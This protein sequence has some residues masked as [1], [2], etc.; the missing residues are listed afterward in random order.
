MYRI[1]K[2]EVRRFR[3]LAGPVS[4]SFGD[5][6]HLVV[7]DNGA[8]KTNLLKLLAMVTRLDFSP[9]AN[10]SFELSWEG[11]WGDGQRL[12]GS[13]R[14]EL[15]SADPLNR[16]PASTR[17]A[18]WTWSVKFT[19]GG[20]RLRTVRR[21][22]QG[23]SGEGDDPAGVFSIVVALMRSSNRGIP[24]ALFDHWSSRADE[25]LGSFQGLCHGVVDDDPLSQGARLEVVVGSGPE[26]ATIGGFPG[27][28]GSRRW[29]E[30]AGRGEYLA[31]SSAEVSWLEQY[32]ADVGAEAIQLRPRLSER[33]SLDAGVD[34]VT[35]RGC[36][37][38]V[39]F[40]AHVQVS[41]DKL[42]FGQKRLLGLRFYLST[43]P[44]APAIIDELSNGL[45]HTWVDSLIRDLEPR[46]SFL[47]TQNPLLM[48]S[49]WWDSA[50]EARR[51]IILCTQ[52][53][54][55]RWVW[56]QLG[57]ADAAT[58]YDAWTAGIQQIH[59]VLKTQGWW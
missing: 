26:G 9:L 58:F 28:G 1:R 45:H 31:L 16:T 21:V 47:A 7:G 14:R 29:A 55:H 18:N 3:G 49:V 57:A 17:R 15:E 8:G 24:P 4:L 48:D 46:Q 44:A 33:K 19:D 42:S 59:E 56:R 23:M 38:Q 32:R 22:G 10:E 43:A 51:G 6:Y 25:A 20:K 27:L 54:E 53:A 50:D 2:L 37:L 40:S 13:V 12:V 5:R 34:E 36:D 11:E 52:D 30:A 41:Q 35:F 39:S